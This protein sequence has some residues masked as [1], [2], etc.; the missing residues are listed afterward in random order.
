MVL[1]DQ[2][3]LRDPPSAGA[4]RMGKYL[5]RKTGTNIGCN[6]IIRLMKV[7]GIEAIYPRK[8]TTILGGSS[9]ITHIV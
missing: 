8:R 2:L 6:R 4:W 5:T 9:G 3:H 1:L 7:M